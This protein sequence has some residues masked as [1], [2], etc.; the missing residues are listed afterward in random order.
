MTDN[1]LDRGWKAPRLRCWCEEGLIK[2]VNALFTHFNNDLTRE[3]VIATASYSNDSDRTVGGLR[4]GQ[5]KR[6]G[7]GAVRYQGFWATAKVAM[8]EVQAF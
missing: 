4:C 1:R 7:K 6:M 5:Q 8:C 2:A 3:F